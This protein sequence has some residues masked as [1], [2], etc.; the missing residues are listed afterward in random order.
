M[1]IIT[2]NVNGI[3]AAAKK[4]LF[5]WLEIQKADYVCLQ[6]TRIQPHQRTEEF[7]Y[8]DGYTVCYVDAKKAG[9]SGVAI[10]AR[11]QP[12]YIHEGLGWA[13]LDSEG[14]WVQFDFGRLSII[15]LYLPSGSSSDIRQDFKYDLME[16]LSPVIQEF[17]DSG[18]EYIICGDINIAHKQIDI[19]NWRSNQKN[20]GFLPEERKWMDWWFSDGGMVDVFRQVQPEADH[21]TWWSNRGRAWEN[22]VGWRIDYQIATPLIAKRAETVEIFKAKRFSDHSPLIIDY[23]VSDRWIKSKI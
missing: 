10:F 2:L 14:R 18:R 23:K 17:V 20:S 3:R 4:G 9:Y 13:D 7:Y 1:R 19:K 8:P 5:E 11:K 12:D 21:Y 22:N 15:S 16:R 6:E